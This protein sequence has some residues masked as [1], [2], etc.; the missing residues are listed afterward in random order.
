ML[1][2]IFD[3]A[4]RKDFFFFT[5]SLVCPTPSLIYLIASKHFIHTYLKRAPKH[6]IA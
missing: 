3:S 2:I 5:G 1:P 6:F 4:V